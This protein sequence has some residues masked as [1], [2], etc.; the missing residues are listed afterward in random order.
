MKSFTLIEMLVSIIIFFIVVSV[1]L[2]ISGNVKHLIN[3]FFGKKDFTLASSIALIQQKKVP[4]LYEQVLDFNITDDEVIRN[5][6][7]YKIKL[8]KEQIKNEFNLTIEKIKAY[9]KYHSNFA[10]EIK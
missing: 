4:N 1:A 5:L 3:I 7:K 8:K 2:S 9:D 10:I 6:K